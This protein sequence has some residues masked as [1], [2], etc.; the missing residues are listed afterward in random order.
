MIINHDLVWLQG[1]PVIAAVHYHKHLR[2]THV[3]Y[4]PDDSPF[5]AEKTVRELARAIVTVLDSNK[6]RLAIHFMYPCAENKLSEIVRAIH[7][8]RPQLKIDCFVLQTS[9]LQ[10]L[11]LLGWSMGAMAANSHDADLWLRRCS[12]PFSSTA[13]VTP[14]GCSSVHRIEEYKQPFCISEHGFTKRALFINVTPSLYTVLSSSKPGI[15]LN[16]DTTAVIKGWADATRQMGIAGTLIILVNEKAIYGQ[17]L[18]NHERAIQ[19]RLLEEARASTL[20]ALAQLQ[21]GCPVYLY[22]RDFFSRVPESIYDQ[23]ASIDT[24]YDYHTAHAFI[25]LERMQP[26]TRVHPIFPLCN[27]FT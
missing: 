16:E 12:V 26:Q 3:L 15:V 18:K 10:N 4:C 21:A 8:T 2:S 19:E 11:L 5:Q 13:F 6:K 14:A 7:R 20:A 17:A 9:A 25:I 27:I 22:A 23:I 24:I 1:P